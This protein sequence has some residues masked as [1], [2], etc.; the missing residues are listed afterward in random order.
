MNLDAAECAHLAVSS[1]QSEATLMRLTQLGDDFGLN[2][3]QMHAAIKIAVGVSARAFGPPVDKVATRLA[4]LLEFEARRKPFRSTDADSFLAALIAGDLDGASNCLTN[5]PSTTGAI[6]PEDQT[7]T[8]RTAWLASVRLQNQVAGREF[9][10]ASSKT[11][12][13]NA[14]RPRLLCLAADHLTEAA[15]ECAQPV[16]LCDAMKLRQESLAIAASEDD[17]IEQLSELGESAVLL[18][19]MTGDDTHLEAAIHW[20]SYAIRLT[21][22]A[23][24]RETRARLNQ[25]CGEAL[26]TLGRRHA[27][28]QR[29]LDAI[30]HYQSARGFIERTTDGFSWAYAYYRL[31]NALLAVARIGDDSGRAEQALSAYGEA[32]RIWSQENDLTWWLRVELNSMTAA[33]LAGR[34][35]EA[36]ERLRCIKRLS[37]DAA[38]ISDQKLKIAIQSADLN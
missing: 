14:E 21:S 4:A 31:G 15:I 13:S 19:E 23:T 36:A 10:K 6:R 22:D 16:F 1:V 18:G 24:G 3:A 25:H 34:G 12:S 8:L 33:L 20:F 26:E 9:E 37:R 32:Q 7:Q 27:D 2:A 29:L 11:D 35:D 38:G 17:R 5:A 28:P 30:E